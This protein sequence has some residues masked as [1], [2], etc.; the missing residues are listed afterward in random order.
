MSIA[1][2]IRSMAAAGATAEAIALAVEAIEAR[3][4]AAASHRAKAAER[5]ARQRLRERDSHVTVTGHERDSHVTLPP[6]QGSQGSSPAPPSPNSPTS[7][8]VRP[9]KGGLTVPIPQDFSRARKADP[10][11]GEVLEPVV[12]SELAVAVVEHRKKLRKPVTVVAARLLA[13]EFGRTRDPPA[14]ARLMIMNGWQG[15]KAEWMDERG[16]GTGGFGGRQSRGDAEFR[17]LHAGLSGAPVAAGA[18]GWAFGDPAGGLFA[19]VSGAE[20]S[21][22]AVIEVE[23]CDGGKGFG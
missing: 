18:G 16:N 2:L 11:P 15:F 3:E 21:G 8:P 19:D 5:K 13:K 4:C 10:T 22:G 14:A 1:A 7:P 6:L 17:A 9:P 23:P 20:R 12:G